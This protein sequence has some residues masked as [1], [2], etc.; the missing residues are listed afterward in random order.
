MR[1]SIVDGFSNAIIL[2][3]LLDFVLFLVSVTLMSLR[4]DI[5]QYIPRYLPAIFAILF[6]LVKIAR[7][8]IVNLDSLPLGTSSSRVLCLPVSH[9]TE[10]QRGRKRGRHSQKYRT[11]E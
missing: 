11:I 5:L 8:V 3:Q 4:Y 1:D 6:V 7:E 2:L 9:S 10:Q